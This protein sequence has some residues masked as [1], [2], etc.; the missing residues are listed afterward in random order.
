MQISNTDMSS[1]LMT[2]Q[3]MQVQEVAKQ[4]EVSVAAQ[5]GADA[6]NISLINPEVAEAMAEQI[7]SIAYT[8]EGGIVDSVSNSVNILA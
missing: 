2:M 5:V 7:S 8:A 4:I 3:N 1:L 6:S